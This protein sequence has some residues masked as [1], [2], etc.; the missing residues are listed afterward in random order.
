MILFVDRFRCSCGG[1]D[2]RR[3]ERFVVD[4]SDE[5]ILVLNISCVLM[6]C[7]NTSAA[8]RRQS[9]RVR[10][11]ERTAPERVDARF[12]LQAQVA[13][14]LLAERLR[15][16]EVLVRDAAVDVDDRHVS[17]DR[18]RI[19][20]SR[21]VHSAVLFSSCPTTICFVRFL[22]V[23]EGARCNIAV[24]EGDVSRQVHHR[25][26]LDARTKQSV[27]TL[28][29]GCLFSAIIVIRLFFYCD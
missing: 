21:L 20:A 11:S 7:V 17:R 27:T 5:C 22:S 8:K 6:G 12:D 15:R 16:H 1:N 19:E 14:G 24:F 26:R 3:Y 2:W 10:W 23:V 18:F 25:C 4:A 13:R 28:K 9:V 29:N